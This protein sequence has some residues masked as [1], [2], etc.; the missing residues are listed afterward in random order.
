ML[1]RW[2]LV[3]SA[4]LA[5]AGCGGGEA[6]VSN[7]VENGTPDTQAASPQVTISDGLKDADESRF[8]SVVA[9]TGLSATLAGP[10]EYTVLVPTNAAFDRLPPGT[11]DRLVQPA[12]REE[13][14]G[15]VTYHVLP[16]SI[17]AAD[18]G[19]AIDTGKGTAVLATMN[20][21]TLTAS[22]D[23][24]NIRLTDAAGNSATVSATDERFKNGVVHRVDRLLIPR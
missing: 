20:G 6:N 24:G 13:L 3:G 19:R 12:A 22:R 23:G 5:L 10:G 16:G 15:V 9:A 21:Q 4:A 1:K 7:V 18:L 14:T 8:R 11:F 2:S 17:L